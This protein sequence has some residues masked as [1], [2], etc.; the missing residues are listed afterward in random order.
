MPAAHSWTDILRVD[1]RAGWRWASTS[2]IAV[3]HGAAPQQVALDLGPYIVFGR[4]RLETDDVGVLVALEPLLA[5]VLELADQALAW[6]DQVGPQDDVGP[7]LHEP[8]DLDADDPGLEDRPVLHEHVLDLDRGGP[9]PAD[10]DH[11]VGP[12]L[13][14]VEAVV[15][16]PVAV[17]GGEVLPMRVRRVLSRWCQ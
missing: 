2:G 16:D 8:V 3:D 10:L 7:D 17:A 6:L 12:A 13:V 1:S 4:V 9:Q 14:P 5:Q 11:V 15:V